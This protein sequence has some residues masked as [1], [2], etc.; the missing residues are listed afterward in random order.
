MM[1]HCSNGLTKEGERKTLISGWRRQSP[2]MWRNRSRLLP[3]VCVI[4]PDFKTHNF[5][6]PSCAFPPGI[7]SGTQY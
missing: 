1:K 4:V 3:K 5:F 7:V 2:S 6:W